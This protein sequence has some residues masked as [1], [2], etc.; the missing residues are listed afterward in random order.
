MSVPNLSVLQEPAIAKAGGVGIALALVF[1]LIA[2]L[3]A[4][5]ASGPLLVTQ[6]GSDTAEEVPLGLALVVTLLGGAIGIG[7]ELAAN[8][9][10]RP[11][12]RSSQAASWPWCLAGL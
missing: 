2:Y 8:R 12:P 5:A 11:G 6:P 10:R 7:L 3:V 9:L 4:D 1:V